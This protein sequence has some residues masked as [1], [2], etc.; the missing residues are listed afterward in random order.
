MGASV[1]DV[2]DVQ[3]PRGTWKARVLTIRRA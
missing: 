3:A 2:V 1:G